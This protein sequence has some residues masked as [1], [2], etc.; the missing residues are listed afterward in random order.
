MKKRLMKKK[1]PKNTHY[2]LDCPHRKF[3]GFEDL[4]RDACK[5]A[6][7]CDSEGGCNC[8][9]HIYKCNYLN[10]TDHEEESLFW[11]GCK[12]CGEYLVSEKVMAKEYARWICEQQGLPTNRGRF[13]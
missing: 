12:E 3:L 1:I 9:I 2:C 7:V 11:D 5:Y 8:R 10:Y 13:K 6:E 4:N